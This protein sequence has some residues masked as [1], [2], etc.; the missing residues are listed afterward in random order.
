MRV[1]ALI[2]ICY[3]GIIKVGSVR[4]DKFVSG[5]NYIAVFHASSRDEIKLWN[6]MIIHTGNVVFLQTSQY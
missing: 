2:A 3:P 4:L 5:I 1:F 6:V